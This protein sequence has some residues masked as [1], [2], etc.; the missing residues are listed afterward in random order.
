MLPDLPVLV[1][2]LLAP[3]AFAPAAF[4]RRSAT[5]LLLFFAALGFGFVLPRRPFPRVLSRHGQP[6]VPLVTLP[7][8][9]MS[10]R[11]D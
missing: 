5:R 9:F 7:R 8:D 11:T 1:L 10:I 4:D 2:S 3:H 6:R